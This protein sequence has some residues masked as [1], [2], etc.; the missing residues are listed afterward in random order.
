MGGGADAAE[1]ERSWRVAQAWVSQRLPGGSHCAE[2]VPELAVDDA[3][4]CGLGPLLEAWLFLRVKS[5]LV[6]PCAT[7][8]AALV[9]TGALRDALAL[10]KET[11]APLA[12]LCAAL[13]AAEHRVED[14]SGSAR[15]SPVE[16]DDG[17][18]LRMV[19]EV[20]DEV[21]GGGGAG[22]GDRYLHR[23][24]TLVDEALLLGDADVL[25]RFRCMVSGYLALHFRLHHRRLAGEE[26]AEEGAGAEGAGDANEDEASR[27]LEELPFA[28]FASSV[29]LLGWFLLVEEPLSEILCRETEHYINRVCR[30]RFEEP[31]LGRVRE[32]LDS[33]A[34]QW[35]AAV[36][37][38]CIVDDGDAQA[39]Q[40]L[41]ALDLDAAAEGA[42]EVPVLGGAGA[43]PSLVHQREKFEQWRARL[44]FHA[45]E[46]LCELRMGELFD[47]ITEY[48]DSAAALGDLK[49]CLARTHQY[50][51]LVLDLGAVFLQRLLHPGANTSTI[52]DVYISTIK[53]LRLLDPAGVLLE[54]ISEPIKA[55]LCKRPDTVR[56]IVTSL[57]DDANSELFEELGRGGDIKPI[58]QS[59]DESDDDEEEAEDAPARK[60]LEAWT[61]DPIEADPRKTARSRRSN[62]ILSMLVH[63]YGS[64][65]LF[66]NEYRLM[67]ADKLLASLDFDADREVR[68]LELLKLRFGEGSM[69]NCEIMIKDIEDSRRINASIRAKLLQPAAAAA[70][71]ARHHHKQP[72]QHPA[73][74]PPQPPQHQHTAAQHQQAAP[75]VDTVEVTIVSK[76]FWPAL[77]GDNIAPHPL[78]KERMAA[79]AKEYSVLKN[80]RQLVWKTSLGNVQLELEFE[81]G[82]VRTF[83]VP[84]L[85]ATLIMHVGE[86]RTVSLRVLAALCEVDDETVRKRMS[87]W[88]NQG[89][90]RQRKEH[91]KEA[92]TVYSAVDRLAEEHH[93]ETGDEDA[94]ERAVSGEAQLEQEIKVYQDFVKGMLNNYESLPLERIHNMLKMFVSSGE[95]KYEKSAEQ[96]GLFLGKLVAAEVL[97]YHG[98]A[99]SLHKAPK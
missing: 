83:T 88:V 31:L 44:E 23:L 22:A 57:T 29:A 70:A 42:D 6:Q 66:V 64:K 96:L 34:L 50:R 33:V 40:G 21:G 1:L 68:N 55:Y 26:E 91:H 63:I 46:T 95:H 54:A 79:I 99:F 5:E 84:P 56:C 7:R 3:L 25:V 20:G 65:E 16:H 32:W 14:R 41:E 12:Q 51:Q 53:A 11:F 24:H 92:G 69:T 98:G 43:G 37:L 36:L 89:V 19:V 59:H 93:L 73:P 62:D 77:F 27:T 94:A 48:P 87:Y 90:V 35:L 78:I 72:A 15:Q 10:A 38:G 60:K 30:G 61:P 97:D 86:R 4:Q 85:A 49:D 39:A 17:L 58:A 9:R 45:F 71:A 2:A 13:D 74:P 47:I 8:F 28:T 67:L 76:Q 82:V 81:G 52:L 80:P 18:G 75:H